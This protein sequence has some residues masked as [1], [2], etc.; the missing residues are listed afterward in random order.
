[1]TQTTPPAESADSTHQQLARTATNI[2]MALACTVTAHDMLWELTYG[3]SP[4]PCLTQTQP[5]DGGVAVNWLKEARAYLAAVS[6]ILDR[7][8][9]QASA[10]EQH[11]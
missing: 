3:P 11:P 2:R 5:P 7:H 1:M 10:P 9:Q 6:Q 4:H 8:Q